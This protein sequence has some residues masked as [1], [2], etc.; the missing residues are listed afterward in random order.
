MPMSIV[1]SDSN[2][3]AM[4][5]A[6]APAAKSSEPAPKGKIEQLVS[7]WP[8]LTARDSANRDEVIH[9]LAKER[10]DRGDTAGQQ[11][12]TSIANGSPAAESDEEEEDD[13]SWYRGLSNDIGDIVPG[14]NLDGDAATGHKRA[15]SKVKRHGQG[16][17][18]KFGKFGRRGRQTAPKKTG[19]RVVRASTPEKQT[20]TN[21]VEMA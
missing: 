20:D 8:M 4:E 10:K 19:G 18:R 2:G 15:G 14:L 6:P 3:A 9:R 5:D 13:V 1:P 16:K 11:M 21:G 17:G 7:S 12:I